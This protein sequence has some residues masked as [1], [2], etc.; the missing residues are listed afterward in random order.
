MTSHVLAV[1][2]VSASGKTT[3]GRRLAERLH[4]PFLE[5]DDLHSPGSRAKM[6]AGQ[7]LDDIDRGPWLQAIA[8]WIAA[9][10]REGTC[11]VVACSALKRAYR[12]TLSGGRPEVRF[13]FLDG[14]REVLEARLH[15][16]KGHFMPP[17]LLD[18]QLRTLERPTEDEHA[19]VVDL[20]WPLQAQEAAVLE[21]LGVGGSADRRDV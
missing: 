1:M 11:G 13:V 12:L 17:D 21:A 19:I 18:S 14:P 16:R 9:R 4:W 2:G 15:A 20:R 8:A 5:G 10:L 3:L 7:P 6:A